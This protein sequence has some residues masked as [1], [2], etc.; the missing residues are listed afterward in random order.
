MNTVV[1]FTRAATAELRERIREGL[2]DLVNH[3]EGVISGG[4]KP[5]EPRAKALIHLMKATESGLKTGL[6]RLQVA[7]A[8]FDQ[9]SI[10]T[11]HG[12]CRQTLLA[13]TLESDLSPD[14]GWFK[15]RPVLEQLVD[16]YWVR[17]LHDAPIHYIE[18]LRE[19]K[20]DRAFLM[21]LAKRMESEPH[22]PLR[23]DLDPKLRELEDPEP[24]L[25]Q[26]W[27]DAIHQLQHT[28]QTHG[29]DLIQWL[30]KSLR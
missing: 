15:L 11:I 25:S 5:K 16:D 8:Q 7:L 29:E 18:M 4:P 27:D 1:S 13:S 10:L 3:I 21:S 30:L 23:M 28:W 26:Q 20:I 2:V 24:A 12:F 14:L 6:K 22:L 17:E 19:Y 9:A